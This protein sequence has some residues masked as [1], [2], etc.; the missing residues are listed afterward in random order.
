MDKKLVRKRR[1]LF[2]YAVDLFIELLE[3]VQKR[4]IDYRCNNAD[5]GCWDNFM[6]EF[7]DNIGEDFIR[8]YT[9]YGIQSWFNDGTVKDYSRSIRFSWIFGKK[10][11]K[12]WRKFDVGT[13]MRIVQKNLKQRYDINT[14][15]IETEI[16][17][18]VNTV[19][20]QE[21]NFKAEFHNTKRGFLWCV[22]NTTLYFHKSPKC[23]TCKFKQ[24][25][26]NI[27][28]NE[29][30]KIYLERGYGKD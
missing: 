11:I 1:R 26:K 30:P 7:G 10:A 9:Q 21:E 23:A 17:K 4:K 25:C 28:E 18:L 19:R 16:P 27:L 13:N 5:S 24:D 3:Q 29:Y 6:D 8:K 12:R 15:K 22:A 20:K 2:K 14:V